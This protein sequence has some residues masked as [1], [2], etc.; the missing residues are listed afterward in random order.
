SLSATAD[1]VKLTFCSVTLCHGG[2][3]ANNSSLIILPI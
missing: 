1:I 3:P 2:A